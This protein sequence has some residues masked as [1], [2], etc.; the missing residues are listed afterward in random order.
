MYS[1]KTYNGTGSVSPYAVPFPYLSKDHVE[2]RIGGV[3]QTSGYSWINSATLS[4]NAVAGVNNVDIRRNTPAGVPVVVFSDGSTLTDSDLNLEALQLLYIEQETADSVTD[5]NNRTVHFPE[6]E[7]TTSGELPIATARAQM[8]LGFDALGN[9]TVLPMPASVGAGDLR[10]D[11]FV[12]GVD[13]TAGTSTSVTLSRA[14]GTTSNVEVFFDG[15]FQGPDQIASLIGMVLTFTSPIPTGVQRVFVRSGTTLSQGIPANGS[16]TGASMALQSV[17]DSKI[18]AGSKLYHRINDSISVKDFGCVGDGVHDDTAT[19]TAALNFMV[20]RGGGRLIVPAGTYKLTA[21]SVYNFATDYQSI[22]LEGDGPD[23][24]VLSWVGGSAGITFNYVGPFNAVHLR[25]LSLVTDQV[26]TGTA[27]RLVQTLAAY[28]APAN[29]ALS[30]FNNVSIR[31]SDGYQV[32][33]YWSIGVDVVKVS[34]INFTNMVVAGLNNGGGYSSVGTGVCVQGTAAAPPVVFN[35]LGCT[36]NGLGIG[37][38]YGTYAQGVFVNQCNFTGGAYGIIT[39]GTLLDQLTVNGSQFHCGS[40]GINQINNAPQSMIYGNLFIVP[41]S[42]SGISFLES[43]EFNIVGNN[44]IS[45]NPV[46]NNGIVV[47]GTVGINGGVI[48]GNTFAGLTGA[49]IWLQATSSHTNV[50]SNFYSS[51]ATNVLNNGSSNTVGGGSP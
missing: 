24:T 38:I 22:I 23:C 39:Q 13:F 10:W 20:S 31:G 29:S 25:D 14:P 51:N 48:T 33:K 15:G 17:D 11:T 7:V 27:V 37:I 35:F 2:V 21:A 16:V 12:A 19:W 1:I 45:Y 34:N 50:Q 9:T 6:G 26:G 36:F 8:V 49:G 28:G 46:S 5:T 40:A 41:G 4:F 30:D 18:L 42:S 32:F 44:F 47:S 3:L 43:Q